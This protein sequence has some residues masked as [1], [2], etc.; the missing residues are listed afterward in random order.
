MPVG[1]V[2]QPWGTINPY[3]DSDLF[4]VTANAPESRVDRE[5]RVILKVAYEFSNGIKLQSISD[6]NRG[7]GKWGTDLDLTD[8]G[9]P[10]D[11]PYFGDTSHWTFYDA[12]PETLY[13]EEIN[14]VSPD[15]QPIT[16]VLGLYAQENDYDWLKPYQF[17]IAVG[18][19]IDA[20][21]TPN[22]G[23]L[24][25]YTS[26]T[27]QGKTTNQDLAAFGQVEAKLGGG[28]SV[29]LGGR[30]T[31]TRSHNNVDIWS[32]G[33]GAFVTVFCLRSVSQSTT[34]EPEILASDL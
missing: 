21:P 30:W 17:W 24:F 5:N 16:W 19:R 3:H 14:L 29:S 2:V 25:Q 31:E 7:F 28:V 4:H 20:N 18:P 33:N 12:V 27:F 8:Y 15:N 32:Y 11:F 1:A 22:P 34:R 26:Y 9:N 23:N 6:Y 13:S 10:G